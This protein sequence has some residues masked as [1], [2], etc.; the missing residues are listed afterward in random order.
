MLLSYDVLGAARA[1]AARVCQIIF[2]RWRIYL[3]S[4]DFQYPPD[5]HSDDANRNE[6]RGRQDGDGGKGEEDQRFQ[7]NRE[8]DGDERLAASESHRNSGVG[9]IRG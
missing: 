2:G 6:E 1:V 8:G 4:S 9:Q 5:I 7:W 3:S